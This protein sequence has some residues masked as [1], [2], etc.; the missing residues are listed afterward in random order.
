[1]NLLYVKNEGSEFVTIEMTYQDAIYLF[2]CL[3][4]GLQGIQTSAEEQTKR[5][6][7]INQFKEVL[8]THVHQ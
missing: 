6:S 7:F 8:D 3:N 1:M 5:I 2:N 4:L